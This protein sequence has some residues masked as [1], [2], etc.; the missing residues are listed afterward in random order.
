[1]L[2][3]GERLPDKGLSI[4]SPNNVFIKGNYNLDPQGAP[5][6]SRRADDGTVIDFVKNRKGYLNAPDNPETPDVD[7]TGL[8]WQPAEII[9]QRTVYT[10]SE[11]FAEPSYMPMDGCHQYQYD[12]EEIQKYVPEEDFVN[13]DRD[14]PTDYWWVP[15]ASKGSPGSNLNIWF[16]NYN[17]GQTPPANWT[18]AWVD[19]NWPSDTIFSFDLY[20]GDKANKILGTDGVMDTFISS[21]DLRADANLQIEVVYDTI[22]AYDYVHGNPPNPDT[23]DTP[24]KANMVHQKHIYNT[25]IVTPYDTSPSV[26]EYWYSYR[27]TPPQVIPRVINGAFIQLPELPFKLPIPGN[28]SYSRNSAPTNTYN[29]ETRYGRGST[30]ASRPRAGLNFGTD[31]S[32]RELRP[33]QL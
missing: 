15:D 11:D 2:V 4:G 22:F 14:Y 32:W 5:E 23:T 1:M 13:G 33:A 25:A 26:L 24:S 18:R 10:L 8:K 9:T 6:K 17:G 3:N 30:Q 31:S 28:V 27:A 7:E 12:D 20:I 29:Y 19:A 16:T 21:Y